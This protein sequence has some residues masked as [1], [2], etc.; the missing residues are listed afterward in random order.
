M[1]TRPRICTPISS[2]VCRARI[3]ASFGAGFDRL[4]RIGPHEIQVGILKRL[5]GAPVCRHAERFGLVFS[6]DPPYSL[7]ASDRIDR[8]TMQRLTRFARYWDLVGNS[9]RFG[10]T[11]PLLLGD[12]PFERFLAWSDWFFAHSGKTHGIPLEHLYEG[13]H[14][15]LS[16]QGMAESATEAL[17]SDYAACGARGRLSFDP[18]RR[19]PPPSPKTEGT[20]PTRQARHLKP[21]TRSSC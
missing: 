21:R 12:A 5:R 20:L 9:G 11:L 13:L 3:P 17:R 6:P 8:A 18:T 4:M 2:S 14:A 10:L 19:I 15:W 1:H 7:L 16:L